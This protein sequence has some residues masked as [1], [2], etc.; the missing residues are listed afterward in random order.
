MLHLT[1]RFESHFQAL[2]L[3]ASNPKYQPTWLNEDSG[4]RLAFRQDIVKDCSALSAPYT[5]NDYPYVQCLPLWHGTKDGIKARTNLG[6]FF[7]TGRGGCPKDPKQAYCLWK[8]SAEEGH[9]RAMKNLAKQLRQGLGVPKDT[10]AANVWE[11]KAASKAG[12]K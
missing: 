5:Q 3:R 4:T 9:P 1:Q 7:L 6:L 8:Q 11:T 10:Y 12:M 2:D